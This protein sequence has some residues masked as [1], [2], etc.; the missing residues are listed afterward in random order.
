MPTYDYRCPTCKKKFSLILS[1]K[2]HDAGK[3]KC[4]KCQGKKVEQLITLF[5]AK[6]SRKS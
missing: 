3:A 6:T 5:Q 2:D 4:P 1:I